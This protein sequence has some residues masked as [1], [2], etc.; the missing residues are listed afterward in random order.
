ML[1]DTNIFIDHF[2]GYAPATAFLEKALQEHVFFSA[3]TETE[4]LAGTENNNETKRR[5]LLHFLQQMTKIAVDNPLTILAGDISRRNAL[6]IP[7]AII[8]ASALAHH[9]TLVTKNVKDFARI[10]GLRIKEPY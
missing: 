6:A 7:D 10:Q 2:R 8:A 9:L 3:I 5:L 4:L 1:L